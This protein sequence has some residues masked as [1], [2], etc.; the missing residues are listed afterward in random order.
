MT[1]LLKKSI[2]SPVFR[3]NIPLNLSNK[4]LLT[5]I[6]ETSVAGF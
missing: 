6:I 3:E 4:Q 1:F 2:S 5:R